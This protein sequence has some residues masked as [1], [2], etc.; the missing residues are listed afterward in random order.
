LANYFINNKDAEVHLILY[1]KDRDIFY[2]IS[3]G[4]KIYKPSFVFIAHSRF[5]SSLKTLLFVRKTVLKISPDTILSFGE[6]W[7]SFVLLALLGLKVPIYISDR[8][9]PDKSL[10]RL[11]DCL[12]K[13]L[14]PKATGIIIQTSKAKEIYEGQGYNVNIKVIANPIHAVQSNGNGKQKQNIILS[15]G[16]LIETKHHDR[17]IKMFKCLEPIGWKL[18]IVGGDALKQS[19]MRKLKALVDKLGMSDCVELTDTVSDVDSYYRQSKIF[20]FTSSSEGFPNVIGEAMSAGLPIIS[21]DCVAGPSDLIED[22]DN[23]FLIPLFNDETYSKKLK[24]LMNDKNLRRQMGSTSKELVKKFSP[25]HTAEYYYLFI[26]GR[27]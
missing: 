5:I 17:L 18:V 24:R 7:N 25:G 16:R 2:P 4:I 9:R 27:L 8:C 12:R 22:G 20:A 15:V 23:G 21:Y 3:D 1:G 6:Y 10:G 14:Y 11:H 19:G 26:L 13:W